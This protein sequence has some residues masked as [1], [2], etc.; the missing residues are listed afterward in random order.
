M[1]SPITAAWWWLGDGY[2]FT[3][4]LNAVGMPIMAEHIPLQ[5]YMAA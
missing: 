5:Y 4:L 2:R 1:H 3:V